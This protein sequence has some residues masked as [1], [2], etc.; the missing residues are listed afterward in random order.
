MGDMG[1]IFNAAKQDS[2]Q[3]RASNRKNSAKLLSDAG[4]KFESKN[5]GAHL[6]IKRSDVTV[7]FWPGTGKW[8]VRG[9]RQ[10][11]GVFQLARFLDVELN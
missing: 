7:D 11:R 4:V 6:I 1:E 3:R 9:G 10:G 8:H 2:Q 5:L